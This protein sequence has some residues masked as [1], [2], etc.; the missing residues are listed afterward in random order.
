MRIKPYILSLL[1]ALFVSLQVSTASHEAASG[2]EHH[3]PHC[4]VCLVITQSDEIADIEFSPTVTVNVPTP[5]FAT[6]V[7]DRVYTNPQRAG[8]ETRAPPPR[9]PPVFSL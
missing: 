1:L 2:G 5:I 6:I 3:E 8:T 4:A 9:A 7:W